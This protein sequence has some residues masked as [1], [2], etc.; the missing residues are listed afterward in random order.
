MLPTLAPGPRAARYKLHADGIASSRHANFLT[1][2]LHLHLL[3]G[4]TR[5]LVASVQ[6]VGVQEVLAAQ[7]AIQHCLGY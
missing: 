4:L 1:T 2:G 3:R 6:H 7:R 5:F